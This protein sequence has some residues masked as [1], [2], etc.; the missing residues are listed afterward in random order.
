MI[1]LILGEARV[2]QWYQTDIIE[3]SNW[4]HKN[5]ADNLAKFGQN[6]LNIV[7]S[8]T[9]EIVDASFGPHIF[10]SDAHCALYCM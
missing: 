2:W 7:T 6:Q 1:L 5:G 10:F 4:K 8:A 9:S 3:T